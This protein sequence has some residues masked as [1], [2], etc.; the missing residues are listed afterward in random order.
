M[1]KK[2]K[3]TVRR[4]PYRKPLLCVALGHD[5]HLPETEATMSEIM[6]LSDH[7]I[8]LRVTGRKFE[9]GSLLLVR[10]P[11][12]RIPV[13]V[14]SLAQVRWIKEEKAGAYQAGLRFVV[15]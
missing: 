12:V 1:T 9:E 5:S 13:S 2:E 10:V 8:R 7:G 6:D 4:F 14:P 11:M 3:R 15:E